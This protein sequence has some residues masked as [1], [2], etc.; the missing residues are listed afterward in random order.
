MTLFHPPRSPVARASSPCEQPPVHRDPLANTPLSPRIPDHGQGC[1][2]HVTPLVSFIIATHNRRAPL[3]NT[4]S[5]LKKIQTPHE[6][7]I[8]DNASTDGT[9]ESVR[10]LFPEVHLLP[11][12]TNAGSCAKNLALPHAKADIIVFLDDD[13]YPD[14]ASIQRLVKKFDEHPALGAAV[15]TITLP[16][17][18]RECSAYPDIFIGCGVA[19]R[20]RALQQAGGLPKDFFMQAEEYDLSLRLLNH[21][22]QVRTFDDLHVTHLKSPTARVSYRTTRLDVRNNL[23]LVARHFPEAWVYPYAKDWLARYWQ[24]AK[25][26]DHRLSFVRG[27][28]DALIRIIGGQDR[29]PVSPAAFEQ[30]AKIEAIYSYLERA[31][32]AHNLKKILFVDYGKNI[33]PYYLAAQ[34]LNLEIVAIADPKLAGAT[35]RCIPVLTDD[36][37]RGLNFDAAIVSNL[38][39]VHAQARTARWT[40]LTTCPVLNFFPTPPVPAG[41]IPG[42]ASFDRPN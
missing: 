6:T 10:D 4:L 20:R 35:Y 32:S 38:S 24:I 31:I 28:A 37:A 12:S 9:L 1:P 3:L 14:P 36:Q 16:D 29:K 21:G 41:H 15:F 11:Q 33:L 34:S 23:L 40:H 39:P 7:L 22:W 5:Q 25:R 27:L 8:V 18:S 42:S 19:F 26:K 13:S 2:C 30:F 17:G